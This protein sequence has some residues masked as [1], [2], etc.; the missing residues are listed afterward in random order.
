MSAKKQHAGYCEYII[1]ERLF[2]LPLVKSMC[3]ECVYTSASTSKHVRKARITYKQ[4]AG[5]S[6]ECTF[7]SFSACFESSSINMCSFC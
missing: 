5:I 1:K 4:P 3:V 7:L 2:L 6:P